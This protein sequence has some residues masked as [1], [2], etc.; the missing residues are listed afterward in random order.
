MKIHFPATAKPSSDP[1]LDILRDAK[2]I[3]VVGLSS[4]PARPS[5]GVG[6]YLQTAGYRII[7]V[8]PNETEILGGKSFGNLEEIPERI[9]VVDVFRRPEHV[10]AI[11]KS[12]IKIGVKTLW[13]QLGIENGEAADRARAAG[14]K[15]IEDA[16]LLVEHKKRRH[17][18]APKS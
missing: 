7:P 17:L 16:C 3:A 14:L 13:L 15:V 6:Q 11:A 4:N 10:P 18:L 5:Y 9:D 12:A 1:I 8:N 2:T